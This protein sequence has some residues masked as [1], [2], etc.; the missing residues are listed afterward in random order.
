MDHACIFPAA[1]LEELD[2]EED[3]FDLS[4]AGKGEAATAAEDPRRRLFALLRPLVP[5]ASPQTP[6]PPPP[7]KGKKVAH[8]NA[9]AAFFGEGQRRT[10][11]GG[12]DQEEEELSSLTM[13]W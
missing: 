12:E 9:L 2:D 4:D 7:S 3:S 5:T 13:L 6:P 8:L 10:R 1:R 11:K